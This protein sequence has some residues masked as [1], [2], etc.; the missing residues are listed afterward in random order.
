[1]SYLVKTKTH[2]AALS[3][4]H[5]GAEQPLCQEGSDGSPGWVARNLCAT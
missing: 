3:D 1:M 2:R 4:S 5:H